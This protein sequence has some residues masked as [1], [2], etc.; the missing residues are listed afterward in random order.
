MATGVVATIL[1]LGESNGARGSSSSGGS[2]VLQSTTTQLV[3]LGSNT[4][5][6]GTIPAHGKSTISTTVYPSGGSS[7]T[8]QNVQLQL[9]YTNPYG[10]TLTSNP[11]AGLVVSPDATTSTLNISYTE[12]ESSPLLTAGKL[13]DLNFVVANNG[14]TTLSNIVISL[15]PPSS[16]LSIVGDSKWTVKSLNPGDAQN[17][18]TKVFAATSLIDTPVSFSVSANYITNGLAKTDSLNLGAYVIGDINIQVNDI[19]ISYVGNTATLTGT[20]LN[21]GST[22]GLFTSV[23]LLHPEFIESPSQNN[24]RARNG[25]SYFAQGDTA[26]SFQGGGSGQFSQGGGSG[27]FSQRGSSSHTGISAD[28][29]PQYI[30]DLSA[31]SPTPFS[32]PLSGDI[33]PGIHQVSFKVVYADSLKHFQE[34]TVNGTVNAQQSSPTGNIRQGSEFGLGIPRSMMMLIYL[35]IT[36]VSVAAATVFVMRKR[37]SSKTKKTKNPQNGKDFDIASLLDDSSNKK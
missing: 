6:V 18:S 36:G 21:Q 37:N 33:N 14:T 25:G 12:H 34:V 3:N 8:T 23:Q 11:V 17:L 10:Y 13:E 32:I 24:T 29:A 7:G 28:S 1:S 4:F 2:L 22:T 9:T 16:S 30:G 26:Q 27:Q 20:L 35:P 15:T 31:D 19:S 5:N